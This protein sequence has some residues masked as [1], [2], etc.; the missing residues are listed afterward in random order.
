MRVTLFSHHVVKTKHVLEV[1]QVELLLEEQRDQSKKL[2]KDLERLETEKN[3]NLQNHQRL[4]TQIESLRAEQASLEA[5]VKRLQASES[6][7][8]AKYSLITELTMC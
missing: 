4:N 5:E 7:A 6:S 1:Q 2:E 8:H 3:A